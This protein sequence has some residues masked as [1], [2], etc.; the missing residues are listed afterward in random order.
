MARFYESVCTDVSSGSPSLSVISLHISNRDYRER[1][2]EREREIAISMEF[3]RLPCNTCTSLYRQISSTKTHNHRFT[4]L[5]CRRE[6]TSELQTPVEANGRAGNNH[7]PSI[8]SHKVTVHDRQRGV[9]HEFLVPEVRIF[10][11][12]F[13]SQEN[14]NC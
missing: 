13:C 3:L 7:F 4:S 2:R 10:A 12:L 14:E 1:E 5:K 11:P 6:T 9:V 8:P